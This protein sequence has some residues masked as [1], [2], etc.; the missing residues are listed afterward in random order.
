MSA[1]LPIVRDGDGSPPGP[2]PEVAAG[3]PMID[4]FGRRITYLR[5]SV[6]DRCNLRCLYCMPAEGLD[7]LP[8]ERLL[9]YEEIARVVR[10]MAEGGVRRVRLTGGEPT[11]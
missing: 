2:L 3:V 11:I 1:R 10:V 8:A 9:S 4:P 6:T 7:W 5:V